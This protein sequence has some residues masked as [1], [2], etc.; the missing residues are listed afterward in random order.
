M[1]PQRIAFNCPAPQNPPKF[2]PGLVLTVLA[3]HLSPEL[4]AQKPA[5]PAKS[6]ESQ[7]VEERFLDGLWS[8][9]Y[10][11]L[12][13]DYL[14]GLKRLNKIDATEIAWL[15]AR[16]A[17][18]EASAQIDLNRRRSILEQA[19]QK[20]TG[21]IKGIKDPVNADDARMIQIQAVI[22]LA[23]LLWIDAQDQPTPSQK[24]VVTK[25][26]RAKY[27]DAR[28]LNS[29]LLKNL[30]ER[31]KSFKLPVLAEDPRRP[32]FEQTQ[33]DRLNAELQVALV[34]YEEAQTWPEKSAERNEKLTKASEVL[35]KLH[36]NNRGQIAGQNARLW[37]AKCLQ[38]LGDLPGA[39]GIYGELVDQ[40]DPALSDIRRRAM[41]FRILAYRDRGDFALAADESRRWLDAYPNQARTEDGLG[42]QLELARNII[43]QMAKA[44][45]NEKVVAERVARE[46]LGAV[47][48]V[49]SKYQSEARK[50]LSQLRKSLPDVNPERLDL[51][52]ALSA[53]QEAMELKDWTRAKL[54]FE[55]AANRAKLAKDNEN[56][57]KARYFE[58]VSLFRA[59]RYYESYVLGN[60]LAKRYPSVPLA[61]NAAEIALASMTYAYNV[62]KNQDAVSD[63]NRLMTL[64]DDIVRTWPESPQADTARITIGEVAR[65]QGNYE[66]AQKALAAVP[67]TSE[68]YAEAR[69]K[70][71]L[72]LWRQSQAGGGGQ[73]DSRLA[74]QAIAAL[75]ESI[76]IRQDQGVPATDAKV[77]TSQ[78]DLADIQSITGNSDAAIKTLT[79]AQ[80]NAGEASAEIKTRIQRLKVRALIAA[81]Q[82]DQALADLATAEKSG[83]SA[84]DLASLYFQLGQALQ[85][86]LQSLKDAK[87]GRYVR[88]RQSYQAFL[89][90]L[91][92]SKVSESWQALQWVAEAQLDDNQNAEALATL[93]KVSR[94]F[95]EN[96]SFNSDPAN[97]QRVLRS[98]I[99]LAEAARKAR[100]FGIANATLK[101]IE[102]KNANLLPLMMERG[103]LLEAEG[104]TNEA[105]LYWRNLTTRL[106]KAKPRPDEYYE[107]WLE[108]AGILEKQG[109]SSTARQSL[110]SVLKLGGAGM[111]AAWKQRFESEIQR[112]STVANQNPGAKR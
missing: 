87:D 47:V 3:A 45:P 23:H 26:A 1:K 17:Y 72:V 37:Q 29:L 31:E 41:F 86:E 109:K 24:D 76:K 8:R 55:A 95:L 102:S 64:A 68:Q 88:V 59:D 6:P 66:Q 103:R 69:S 28:N 92:S 97:A 44:T 98:Q 34:D 94:Q 89:K 11:D 43:L 19:I 18:E 39:S 38:E 48:R 84:E 2:W 78:L 90:A 21:A 56:Y 60:H 7:S 80:N 22:E 91:A 111:N 50:L 42:V 81:E 107:A 104:K 51:T 106:S 73:P 61:A 14:A 67:K 15:E 58:A 46:R 74:A 25:Q 4:L 85:E 110:T 70:L 33:L 77:L 54:C 40:A 108:I 5:P 32:A 20:M 75:A 65:G 83:T 71:G 79:D 12:A 57:V 63:L 52:S 30:M 99:K 35:K 13:S 27:L 93:Q 36:E 82:L 16:S 100:Q 62:F 49:Y 9:G 101:A 10:Y 53:G 96:E 112:L 105:F